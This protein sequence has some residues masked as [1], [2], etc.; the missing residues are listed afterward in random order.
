MKTSKFN[1]SN[2]KIALAVILSFSLVAVSCS[3]EDNDMQP[4]EP[5]SELVDIAT[6]LENSEQYPELFGEQDDMLK[7]GGKSKYVAKRPPT[8]FNL[9]YALIKTNLLSTVARNQLTVIAPSD[10]A[11]AKLFKELGVRGIRDLSAEQLKPILLYHVIQGKVFSSQLKSGFVPTLN[12]AAVEV[13]L[14]GGVM[15]NDANVVFANIRALNGVIHVIDKVLIPPTENLVEKALSF[16]PEFSIL[17][18]AVI[19]ANLADV[20]ATGGPFT[21]FAP[22]NAA[23]VALLGELGFASLE[24]LI[25]EETGIGIA[26]LTKVLLYHV[27]DGRV[28]SSDLPA[29]PLSVT[30]LSGDSFTVDA[31]MLKITDFNGRESGLIPTLLNVQ[32]TNGVIHVIDTVILPQ[33]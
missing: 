15:F 33:L 19:A 11:F 27:V 31:S 18:Q 2:G 1:L 24:A 8:F 12:G 32:A 23:F 4:V 16:D 30:T 14:D 13:K 9:T 6:I 3:K 21:V 7:R 5:Q 26:G 28:Y 29:G 10:E 25:N 22:T 20:L 17:V